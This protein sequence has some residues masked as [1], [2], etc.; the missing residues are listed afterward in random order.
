MSSPFPSQAVNNGMEKIERIS[1]LRDT[2]VL[3]DSWATCDPLLE[4]EFRLDLDAIA[5]AYKD[6]DNP[7]TQ[8]SNIMPFLIPKII[9]PEPKTKGKPVVK[10]SKVIH[11][12]VSFLF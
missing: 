11:N 5:S 10:E 6:V 4:L 2:E 8:P 1:K 9:S 12:L 3:D 7:L